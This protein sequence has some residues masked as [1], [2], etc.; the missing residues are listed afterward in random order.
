MEKNKNKLS[1]SMNI[2][3]TAVFASLYAVSVIVLAPISFGPI[4]IRI[5]DALIPLSIIYGYP[6]V[7]G[8]TLGNVIANIYGG[9]GF[10][11][12]VGGTLANLLASYSAFKLRRHTILACISAALIIGIIVGTYLGYILSIP[13]EFTI[14]SITFSSLISI[15]IIGYTLVTL[16]KQRILLNE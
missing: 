14:I 3:L 13:S 5:A 7:I 1:K 12:I 6:V 11:D 8:V 16:L 9:F 4:Q 10:I 15:T 2:S